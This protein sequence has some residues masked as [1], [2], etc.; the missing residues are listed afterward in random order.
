MSN[1]LARK[2]ALVI[3]LAFVTAFAPG[4]G[5]VLTDALLGQVD[6][7]IIVPMVQKSPDLYRDHK[8]VW[9][10]M[11]VKVENKKDASYLEVLET[12]LAY[13][14]RPKA[15][16][17][18]R[19]RFLIKSKTY[20]DPLIYKEKNDVTVAGVVL[21]IET[22]KIGE[23]DYPYPVIEP[24][25]MRVFEPAPLDSTY[26]DPYYPP[27]PYPYPDPYP[28]YPYYGP[29]GPFG[30]LDPFPFNDPWWPYVP[31]HHHKK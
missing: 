24:L 20:L 10:G 19:G 4:C 7:N 31:P 15:L 1:V 8:V 11:I 21:G 26:Y 30:P 2:T 12:G 25:E 3:L 17:G 18:S 29:Y 9:G 5:S 6:R 27:Y 28:G 23:T 22:R 13:D 16:E 14:D